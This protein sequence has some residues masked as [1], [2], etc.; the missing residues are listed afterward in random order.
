MEIPKLDIGYG[1]AHTAYRSNARSDVGKWSQRLIHF[2]SVGNFWYR[3]TTW[4]TRNRA[5]E[6]GDSGKLAWINEIP[7]MIIMMGGGQGNSFVNPLAKQKTRSYQVCHRNWKLRIGYLLLFSSPPPPLL[8]FLRVRKRCGDETSFRVR[9]F[10][11]TAQKTKKKKDKNKKEKENG[12]RSRHSLW[13]NSIPFDPL[14]SAP[15]WP[16]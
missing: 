14:D 3:A 6:L 2:G 16:R 5:R 13:L 8:L 7:R 12:I 4:P 11:R 9:I 15:V 1:L 10:K